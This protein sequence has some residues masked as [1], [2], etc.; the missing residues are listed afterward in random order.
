[1]RLLLSL[2]LAC[3]AACVTERAQSRG[4]ASVQTR[5]ARVIAPCVVSGCSGQI[6]AGEPLFSTCEWR[7]EYACFASATCAPQPGGGCG[8]SMTDA[9][10]ACLLD[11]AK[12]AR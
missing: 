4:G 6:C 9:L 2:S 8:W 3:T 1:M 12:A 7:P 11:A 5:S 10:R